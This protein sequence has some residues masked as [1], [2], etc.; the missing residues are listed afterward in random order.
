MEKIK[1]D[2]LSEQLIAARQKGLDNRNQSGITHHG[3][4]YG[5][6]MYSLIQSD[7]STTLDEL[8]SLE[9]P[10]IWVM[11]AD[12]QHDFTEN[13][14]WLS[15]EVEAIIAFGKKNKSLRYSIESAVSFYARKDDLKEALKLL[16]AIA[17]NGNTVF[18]SP[19][20]GK[21]GIQWEAE[22]NHFLKEGK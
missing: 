3:E 7:I 9:N 15:E 20:I 17:N 14:T 5:M 4:Y 10:V 19:G 2:T 11:S 22:F 6:Q 8:K 16:K 21:E 18:F 13:K 1:K 12:T